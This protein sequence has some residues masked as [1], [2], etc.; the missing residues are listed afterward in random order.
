MK[1]NSPNKKPSGSVYGNLR[2]DSFLQ[3]IKF[4]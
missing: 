4:P 2:G 3:V 1:G